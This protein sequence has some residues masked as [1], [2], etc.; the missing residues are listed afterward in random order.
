MAEVDFAEAGLHAL[1]ARGY[2][3]P[4]VALDVIPEH[5]AA[6]VRPRLHTLAG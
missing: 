4:N 1:D 2:S 3:L 6:E 5:R